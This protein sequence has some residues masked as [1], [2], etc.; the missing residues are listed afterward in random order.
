MHSYEFDT[1][2]KALF[3]GLALE[4]CVVFD[5]PSAFGKFLSLGTKLMQTRT[6]EILYRIARDSELPEFK[7]KWLAYLSSIGE[8]YADTTSQHRA[9]AAP[10]KKSLSHRVKGSL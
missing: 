3:F 1:K 8:S 4:L 5:N 10:I 2:D 9:V 6:P 7:Q